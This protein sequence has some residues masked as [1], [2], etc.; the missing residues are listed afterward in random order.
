MLESL[1]KKWAAL[2]REAEAGNLAAILTRS[3]DVVL[4]SAV[5]MMVAMMIVPLPTPL[6]DVFLS[7]N[8]TAAITLLMVSVYVSR[9]SQIASYP[10]LLLITTL[11]RLSLD[12]SATRLILL[13][14]DAGSVIRS[15][16]EFVVQG[17]IVVGAVIFLI[18]TLVQFI[19]I[20]K[21]AE[22]VAEVS[23]RF[24]LDAMPGKQMAIDHDLH[25]GIIGVEQASARREALSR[26]S[27]FYGAM[28]G[29]MKFVKGDAIASIVITLVN[30]VAGLV[31]GV[32][33]R[34]LSLSEAV[35]TY[36]ILSIGNGLV[37]QIPALLIS[38]SAGIVVTRVASEAKD[39]TLGKDVSMQILAQPKAI[40][41]TTVILGVMALVP[42]LPTVPFLLL[43][44]ITGAIA[45]G[46]NRGAAGREQA[47]RRA[48]AEQKSVEVQLT[49]PLAIAVGPGVKSWV[50][51][52]TDE[53]VRFSGLLA[54]MR[55]VLYEELGLALLPVQL[56]HDQSLFGASFQIIV[57]GVA[58]LSGTLALDHVM[59]LG[60]ESDLKQAAPTGISTSSP[61]DGQ[62]ARLVPA[63]GRPDQRSGD[64]VVLEPMQVIVAHCENFVRTHAREFLG[65]QEV[66]TLLNALKQSCPELVAEVIP[67]AITLQ[68]LTEVLRRLVDEGVSIRDVKTVLQAVAD[69]ASQRPP[70]QQPVREDQYLLLTEHIR[71]ALSRRTLSLL[72]N[73]QRHISFHFLHPDV[74][75]IFSDSRKT[76]KLNIDD[77]LLKR[78]QD[79]A[80][81]LFHDKP[82]TAQRPIIAA[83]SSIRRYVREALHP[84]VPRLAVINFQELRPEYELLP[85]M[86]RLNLAAPS[87]TAAAS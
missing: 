33:M 75:N 2:R 71:V 19:V 20:T 61:V 12:I 9:G 41:V 62:T 83:D 31:I 81:L 14:G 73:N 59:V 55:N 4:V 22:R 21:G 15:F 68:K 85:G 53:G 57:N 43:A 34:G 24:T 42:G 25:S 72:T 45:F 58:G 30:I 64:I 5:A 3:S 1:K 17:N 28:D 37:S 40:L 35:D 38:I 11:Y 23:A 47:Q 63:T 80:R 84:A 10:A 67:K 50:D 8:I 87:Q 48:E 27:Q 70:S 6:L 79:S 29:A 69:W 56:G 54:N 77:A 18:I 36:S 66:Q 60:R 52:A 82:L 46:L 7:L 32:L 16:G 78:L 44:A 76:G 74:V 39:S 13:Q 86:E 49:V 65:L 51:P 26:E